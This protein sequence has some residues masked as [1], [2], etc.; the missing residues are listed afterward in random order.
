MRPLRRSPGG[1][2]RRLAHGPSAA[3]GR[4]AGGMWL[5][6][7]VVPRLVVRHG[8]VPALVGEHVTRGPLA[9]NLGLHRNRTTRSHGSPRRCRTRT[10]SRR[11]IGSGSRLGPALLLGPVCGP[12]RLGRRQREHLTGPR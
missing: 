11:R 10:R 8:I 3:T 5:R 1:F 2:R 9:G 12:V 6:R 7:G 4:R